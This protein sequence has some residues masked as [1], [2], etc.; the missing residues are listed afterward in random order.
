MNWAEASHFIGVS[1]IKNPTAPDAGML[2]GSGSFHRYSSAAV[3]AKMI[4][5][6]LSQRVDRQ[7]GSNGR[8]R[9]GLGS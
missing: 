5:V 4:I 2:M 7:A 9:F 8:P 3:K 1:K 6:G